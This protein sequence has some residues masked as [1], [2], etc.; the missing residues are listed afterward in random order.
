MPLHVPVLE[1]PRLVLTCHQVSDFEES[2]AMWSDPAVTR[3]ISGK[4]ATR[5]EVWARLLRYLGLWA[6]LGYGCWVVRER[7]AGVFVG[8]VGLID[9]RRDLSPPLGET[10]EAAWV[11]SPASH[12]KGYATEAVGAVLNWAKSHVKS[13]RI[14]CLIH[15]DNQ[16]SIRV[17]AK[18]GFRELG[19]TT[20]KDEPVIRFERLA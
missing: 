3:Y 1:T 4:P 16:A 14:A 19:R 15:P 11:L 12:G 9:F 8:E 2:Y 20:Y 17:A 18:C 6:L 7:G 10:P 5:E 13:E